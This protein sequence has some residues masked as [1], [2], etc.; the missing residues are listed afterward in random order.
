MYPYTNDQK[1]FK[2]T[3]MG[4][5]KTHVNDGNNNPYTKNCLG[6][7]QDT[8]ET[9]SQKNRTNPAATFASDHP[10]FWYQGDAV[11]VG[12]EGYAQGVTSLG[13]SQLCSENEANK[14]LRAADI[15]NL[16]PIKGE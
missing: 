14:N 13:G 16:V 7:G 2:I 4:L 15:S 11:G 5:R 1:S 9:N 12:K 3:F 10:T 8:S 6:P